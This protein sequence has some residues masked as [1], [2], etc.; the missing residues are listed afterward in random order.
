MSSVKSPEVGADH[1]PWRWPSEFSS[2]E[3]GI[4]TRIT[5]K[6]SFNRSWYQGRG[7][8]GGLSAALALEMM[9]RLEPER[10]PRSLTL[11]CC[12][13]ALSGATSVEATLE[14]RGGRVS[15]L[16]ARIYNES[17]GEDSRSVV[18]FAGASFGTPRGLDFSTPAISPPEAPPPEDVPEVPIDLPMMPAFCQHFVYRFC[19]DGLPYSGHSIPA[20]GGWCDLRAPGPITYPLIAALL[21][22]WPPAVFAALRGPSVGASLDF[23]YHFLVTPEQLGELERPFLYR[24]E[25]SHASEGYLEERDWLW[26]RRGVLVATARQLIAVS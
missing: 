1:Y 25:V 24:G 22:A 6:G 18:A 12:A 20:L 3:E 2:A 9:S 21:D 7:V 8:Y 4:G 10:A 26:D 11:F 13:P 14:R 19:L 15:H 17:E 23:S 5:A 16:S